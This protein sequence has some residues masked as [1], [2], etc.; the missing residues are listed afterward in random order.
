M[1][2]NTD[3]TQAKGRPSALNEEARQI[4]LQLQVVG[5]RGS[6]AQTDPQSEGR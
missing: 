5:Q 6:S 1:A 4:L 2:L 3:Q